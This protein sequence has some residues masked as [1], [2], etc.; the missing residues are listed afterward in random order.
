ME[1]GLFPPIHS[2]GNTVHCPTTSLPP[3]PQ[4]TCKQEYAAYLRDIMKRSIA[5][6][7][8]YDTPLAGF[9]IVVN[10]GNGGGLEWVLFA[11]GGARGCC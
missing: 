4:Q 9:K 3:G 10:P 2:T 6:P 8:S 1:L 11:G 5:H 7:T